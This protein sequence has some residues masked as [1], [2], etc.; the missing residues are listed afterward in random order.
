MSGNGA[1]P[2]MAAKGL[3]KRYGQVVA[4]GGA[5]FELYPGESLRQGDDD[6]KSFYGKQTKEQRAKANP[7][8]SNGQSL[9]KLIAGSP[10]A[11]L[12]ADLRAVFRSL[13]KTVVMV[14]H[15]LAEAGW[16]GDEILLLRSGRILQRGAFSALLDQ[17]AEPF[18]TQFVN[19]QR[20][21]HDL[22]DGLQPA[23][24]RLPEI[25][26]QLQQAAQGANATFAAYGQD[27]PFERGTERL[28]R[29]VSEAARRLLTSLSTASPPRD[30]A[31]EAH[32]ARE[33]AK[34]RYG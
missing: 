16:F 26:D 21:V 17:P 15:D 6:S 9:D 1:G 25:S 34:A 7:K 29:Q 27:S 14:T 32:K 24:Q 20:L 28:M 18:V 33:R 13:E 10:V 2:V 3:V 23:L 12:Q 31:V 5:D 11:E 4:L 8:P 22:D 30:R 19:A